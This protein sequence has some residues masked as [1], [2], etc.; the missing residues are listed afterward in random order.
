[1]RPAYVN[2]IQLDGRM[3][4]QPLLHAPHLPPQGR[5][6]RPTHSAEIYMLDRSELHQTLSQL[7]RSLRSRHLIEEMDLGA[8][9]EAAR[10]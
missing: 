5:R 4:G 9:L 2:P 3:L 10:P 7:A 6:P 1:M 8:P